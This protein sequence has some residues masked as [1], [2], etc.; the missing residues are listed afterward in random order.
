MWAHEV[1]EVGANTGTHA[2]LCLPDVCSVLRVLSSTPF[3]FFFSAFSS[4]APTLHRSLF[5]THSLLLFLLLAGPLKNRAAF[6]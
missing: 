3:L 5:H 2:G 4:L 1:S 6:M